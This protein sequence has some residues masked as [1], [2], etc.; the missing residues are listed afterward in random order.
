MR[1][2]IMLPLSHSNVV[3]EHQDLRMCCLKL[4]KYN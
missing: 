1:T 4:K 3:F 2:W